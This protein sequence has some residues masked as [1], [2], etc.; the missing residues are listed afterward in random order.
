MALQKPRRR[1]R[2]EIAIAPTATFDPA[3]FSLPAPGEPAALVADL[4]LA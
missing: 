1:T 3:G 4:T 2:T